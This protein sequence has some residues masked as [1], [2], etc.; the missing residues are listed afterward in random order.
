MGTLKKNTSIEVTLNTIKE[1]IH[2]GCFI[3]NSALLT[4]HEYKIVHV[5]THP[6]IYIVGPTIECDSCHA[7]H[8]IGEDGTT[9]AITD[10]DYYDVDIDSFTYDV[11]DPIAYAYAFSNFN[12]SVKTAKYKNSTSEEKPIIKT[13]SKLIIYPEH[14]KDKQSKHIHI[15]SII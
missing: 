1:D 13:V 11:E 8:F 5:I 15:Q 7:V 6:S 9:Y 10:G 3:C 12:T 14:V 2:E 4:E